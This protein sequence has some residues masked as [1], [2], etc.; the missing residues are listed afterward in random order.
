MSLILS[1]G[2]ETENRSGDVSCENSPTID[3]ALL[4]RD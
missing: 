3:L 2:A 1:A 4:F